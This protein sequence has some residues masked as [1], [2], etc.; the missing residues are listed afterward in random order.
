MATLP[1]GV[2]MAQ[3]LA[4]RGRSMV[5]SLMMGLALGTGGILSPVVGALADLY[6]ITAV[7]G[8]LPAIPLIS[9]ILVVRLPN[10]GGFSRRS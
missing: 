9:M 2:A 10:I 5:S 4:P 1:L 3:E 8:W 6:G 7:L